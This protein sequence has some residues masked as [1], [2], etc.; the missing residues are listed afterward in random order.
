MHN[1]LDYNREVYR[2]LIHISSSIIPLTIYFFSK[3]NV[4]PWL[5]FFA[6]F[7]PLL[8]YLR[9]Y[10]LFLKK[11]YYYIFGY[12]TRKHEEASF[13]GA[14][15]VFIGSAITLLLFNENI[16]IISLLILSLSDSAAAIIGIKFGKTKL[17]KKS[18]EGSCA[19]FIVSASILIVLT[20]INFIVILFISLIFTL[21]ELLISPKLNDNLYIPLIAGILLSFLI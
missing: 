19:F 17:F 2:K 14:T 5:I 18:L 1:I 9:R 15:W 11:L 8:D 20:D 4:L 3:D 16:A 10:V 6:L 13:S 7:F 21:S 12:V